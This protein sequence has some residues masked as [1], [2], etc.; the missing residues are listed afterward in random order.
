MKAEKLIYLDFF[1]AVLT[2]VL[3]LWVVYP[4]SPIF[5][6]IPAHIYGLASYA[7]AIVVL[8]LFNRISSAIR[9]RPFLIVLMIANVGYILFTIFFL[10]RNTDTLTFYGWIYFLAEMLIILV[11]I[12][13][14]LKASQALSGE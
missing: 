13:L 10:I 4:L 1:G 8:H 6:I 5:G 7:G 14:E 3:L 12:R 9:M 11:I 2:T